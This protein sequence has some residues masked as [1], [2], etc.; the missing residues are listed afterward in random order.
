MTAL[1]QTGFMYLTDWMLK[2]ETIKPDTVSWDT[3]AGWIYAFVVD[4]QV[5]YIG[6]T[7][8]VL[9]SRLDSYSYQINDRVGACIKA[10]LQ[11][12]RI[13]EIYGMP[14]KLVPQADLEREESQ[15][16]SVHSPIWNVRR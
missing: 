13:V 7:T 10:E 1:N 14:R 2:G 3:T 8:G 12:G 16:I 15:L 5:C 11:S 4:T 6:I 9:R